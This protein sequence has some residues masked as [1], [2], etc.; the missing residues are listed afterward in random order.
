MH[1]PLTYSDVTK[2]KTSTSDTF[3]DYSETPITNYITNCCIFNTCIEF[4]RNQPRNLRWETSLIVIIIFL[5]LLLFTVGSQFPGTRYF[6][7]TFRCLALLLVLFLAVV[8]T[9]MASSGCVAA[10][11]NFL[12]ELKYPLWSTF[13]LVWVQKQQEEREKWGVK[14]RDENMLVKV[15]N[16][17]L[18]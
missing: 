10:K 11:M 5:L 18:L 15:K 13:S 3:H 4:R 9:L 8:F 7:R 16:T 2:K 17:Y 12:T 14:C 1:N 6:H